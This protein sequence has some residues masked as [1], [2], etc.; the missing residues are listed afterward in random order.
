MFDE[1]R[2]VG[3]RIPAGPRVSAS[4]NFPNIFFPNAVKKKTQ[5]SRLRPAKFAY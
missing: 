3:A 4:T 2:K 1:V 5:T